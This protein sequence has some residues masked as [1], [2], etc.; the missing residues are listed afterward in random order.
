MSG[1]NLWRRSYLLAEREWRTEIASLV[2]FNW[3]MCPKS[4]SDP[5]HEDGAG[6]SRPHPQH[7]QEA[8]AG[9]HVIVTIMTCRQ[10]IVLAQQRIY[11]SHK[12]QYAKRI[13]I[14]ICNC[15]NMIKRM[16]VLFHSVSDHSQQDT[17]GQARIVHPTSNRDVLLASQRA[18]GHLIL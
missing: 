3:K 6:G 9:R 8:D 14:I 18:L 10:R 12:Q 17:W 5:P 13:L 15:T 11:R 16:H 4:H 2:R 1:Y 7:E